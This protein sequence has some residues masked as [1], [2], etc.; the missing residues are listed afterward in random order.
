MKVKRNLKDIT[1]L[2]SSSIHI[3][4]SGHK[5]ANIKSDAKASQINYSIQDAL[6]KIQDLKKKSQDTKDIINSL[7]N[8]FM[9]ANMEAAPKATKKPVKSKK[10]E[11]DPTPRKKIKTV[12]VPKDKKKVKSAGKITIKAIEESLGI[13]DKASE[14]LNQAEA[15]LKY[16]TDKFANVKSAKKVIK[17]VEV[18]VK[19]MEANLDKART[20]LNTIAK[21]SG[22]KVL[23]TENEIVDFM[24]KYIGKELHGVKATKK[25][26]INKVSSYTIDKGK[27]GRAL[28]FARYILLENLPRTM[29]K[30]P[31]NLYMVLNTNLA[32]PKASTGKI[33]GK[34]S[35]IYITFV[36][37]KT[38]P[39]KLNLYRVST[40]KEA[41]N[42][43]AFLAREND[44]DV[45]N[46]E[47]KI[48]SIETRLEKL[49]SKLPILSE[50]G[51]DAIKVSKDKIRIVM[52]RESADINDIQRPNTKWY[53]DLFLEVKKL[54]GLPMK[55][56]T[57]RHTT[58]RLKLNQIQEKNGKYAFFFTVL[59]MSPVSEVEMDQEK[60]R[61]VEQKDFLDE[62]EKSADPNENWMAILRDQANQV[63]YGNKEDY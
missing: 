3:A 25:P 5:P 13:V 22:P 15:L 37:F 50:V 52:P 54:A 11:K 10:V 35:D 40:A 18:L 2:I 31:V 60:E 29:K 34:F 39:G 45:F 59:P 42:V 21:Q 23:T 16:T 17:E 63:K 53:K 57:G 32:L 1:S 51:A 20:T 26:K 48:S 36:P 14:E 28:K 27:K 38:Q 62:L 6:K 58:D 30:P 41:K 24:L 55:P 61:I 7:S 46:A 8:A 12:T 4:V 33:I 49:G 47:L 56:P 43:L 19:A 9:L 44:L